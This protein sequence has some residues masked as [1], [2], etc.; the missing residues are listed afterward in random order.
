MEVDA[1]K[2]LVTLPRLPLQDYSSWRSDVATNVKQQPVVGVVDCL[3]ALTPYMSRAQKL[4]M[5]SLLAD[6]QHIGVKYRNLNFRCR[7]LHRLDI[8]TPTTSSNVD[9]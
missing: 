5:I 1:S 7:L 8:P 4:S 3:R 6:P 2:K 9:T